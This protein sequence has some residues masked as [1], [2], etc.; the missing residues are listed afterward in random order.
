M[1]PLSRR[2]GALTFAVLL[3]CF[4]SG[5]AVAQ[6]TNRQIGTQFTVTADPVVPRPDNQPCIVPLFT[7]DR[8]AFFSDTDET[9]EYTPPAAC[10]GPWLKVVLELDFSENPGIQ[11][12]RTASLYVGNT[13]LYFGTTP[14][15]LESLTNTWHVERDV[16]DYSA[17]L[18]SPHQGT[19]VLQNCTTDC[20]PPYNTELN[21]VFTVNAQLEFYP[22]GFGGGESS[23]IPDVVFPLEQSNGS[24]GV[25]LPA[26]VSSPTDQFSTTF[27]LPTNIEQAYLD[28]VSQSQSNDEQWYA[29]FPND[30]SSINDLFGCGNTDFRETEIT[31]DGQPAGIAPVSP[32]VFTGFIPDQWV[33]MPAAQTLDFV[34]YRVNLTPFAALLSDGNPHTVALSVFNAESFFSETASLLLFLDH[35]SSHVTGELTRNTLAPPVP[36][37]KNNLHGTTTVTGTIGITS[38]RQFTIAGFVNTSQ[39]KIA[40]SL[41]QQQNFSGTQTIDFDVVNFTVLNQ[42]VAVQN[43]VARTTTVSTSDGSSVTYDHFSF[44]INV[45]VVFPVSSATFGFTVDTTQNYHSDKQILFGATPVYLNSVTN[46]VN[47]SDVSPLSSSQKYTAFDSTGFTYS[48]QIASSEDTLKTVSSGCQSN[49]R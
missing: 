45:N 47:S 7:G 33:P 11:F 23:P 12:D 38:N 31:I 43:S 4:I 16:T 36:I 42:N 21:G 8:F 24:G 27:T 46:A 25:S 37:E 19:M 9:F 13:N 41:T 20:P 18:T 3:A 17:L 34:P 26:T 2:F 6:S 5:S 28:V 39:G 10:R 44:P 30:L 22:A 15:P 48:C 32:W 29:C 35:G 40:T 1:N 14:E 49:E